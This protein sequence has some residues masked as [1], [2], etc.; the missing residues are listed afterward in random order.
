M[1]KVVASPVSVSAF[2]LVKKSRFRML[3]FKAG[4]CRL[5]RIL[6]YN[7]PTSTFKLGTDHA[8]I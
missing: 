1:T 5:P 7:P 3:I 2:E 4:R 6:L 8:K